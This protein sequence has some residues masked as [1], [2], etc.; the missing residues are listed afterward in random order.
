LIERG[1]LRDFMSSRY[2]AARLDLPDRQRAR[3]AGRR[4]LVR[5]RNTA[6]LPLP[7]STT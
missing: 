7:S 2:T 3:L 5:M 4:A 6:I 1:I